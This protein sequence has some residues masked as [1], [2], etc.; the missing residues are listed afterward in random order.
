M[1]HQLGE[2]S[3]DVLDEGGAAGGGEQALLGQLA[4][5]GHSH[6]IRTQGG[7]DDV[8]E[9]QLLQTGD[10]LAQL[11]VGELRGDGGSHHGVDLAGAAVLQTIALLQD[12]NGIHDEGLVGNGAEGA[13]VHASAALDALGVVDLSGL[14]LV[15]GDGLDLTSVLA[16]T[17]AVDDGGEGTYLGAGAALLAL[18]LVDVGHVIPI[19]GQGTELTDVLATVGQAAA[20]GVGNLVAAYGALV[21]GDVDDLDDVGVL[22]VTADGQ[23]HALTQDGALLV[24]AAAHGGLLAGG[25]LLGNIHHIL[26]E[27]VLP[28]EACHLAQ[29]FILQMLNFRVKFTHD[30]LLR[31]N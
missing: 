7:L 30:L 24:D 6:H 23:L 18:G 21:A 10:D 26:H 25:Q 2:I 14:I 11:G 1:L 9:A 8:S 20:A 15:H 4:S 28:G 3:L 17:L 12:L 19:E 29:D 27:L 31:N 5:L 16:G 22:L 13:L